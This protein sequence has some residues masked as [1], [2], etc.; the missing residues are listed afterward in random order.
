MRYTGNQYNTDQWEP[1]KIYSRFLLVSKKEREQNDNSYFSSTALP[2]K[3]DHLLTSLSPTKIYKKSALNQM[4][5]F[6]E[7][8]LIYHKYQSGYRQNHSTTTLQMKLY[9]DIKTSMKKSE[10]TIAVFAD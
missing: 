10:I 4:T 1:P 2:R 7:I 6:N 8:Q 5:E 9:D 3:Q